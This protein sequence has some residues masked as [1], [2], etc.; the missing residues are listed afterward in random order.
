MEVSIIGAGTV[1]RATGMGLYRFGHE[2]IFFDVDHYKLISSS[3]YR[4]SLSIKFV[5]AS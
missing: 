5:I 2:A 1:G 3:C 4:L